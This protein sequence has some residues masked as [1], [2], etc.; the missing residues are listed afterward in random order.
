[1]AEQGSY[2]LSGRKL[3]FAIPSYDFKVTLK[4]ALSLAKFTSIC[5][6]HGVQVAFGSV[7]GCSVVSRARNLLVDQFLNTDCTDL[8]FIDADINFEPEDVIRLLAWTSRYPIV[9]GVP[10]ARKEERTYIATLDEGEGKTLTMDSMGLVRVT[11][12]ATAFMMVKRE[13]FETLIDAHPEWQYFDEKYAENGKTLYSI[14]DFKSTLKG[15]IG[16]DF[17]FCDRAR[18]HGFEAWVDPT[19]KLGHMGITEYKGDFGN[20]CLYPMLKPLDVKKDV[21]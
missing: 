8:L 10:R 17:L 7:C 9:G 1:M 3:F 12:L 11:R 16:E 20:D 18:A 14:F 2:D 4:F 6:E 13:V 15:Y 19:I 5:K 21:A